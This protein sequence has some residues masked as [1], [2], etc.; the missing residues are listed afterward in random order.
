MRNDAGKNTGR[1]FASH[2]FVRAHQ[3]QAETRRVPR[4]DRIFD[5]I[6]QDTGFGGKLGRHARN[7]VATDHGRHDRS[8]HTQHLNLTRY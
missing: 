5:E 4:D 8:W 3:L 1:R 2:G 7:V 6:G